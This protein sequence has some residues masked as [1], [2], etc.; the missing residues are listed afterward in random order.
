MG[1]CGKPFLLFWMFEIFSLKNSLV[2]TS[3]R[4][5]DAY[6]SGSLTATYGI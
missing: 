6:K 1:V 4:L 2:K 5:T 3:K